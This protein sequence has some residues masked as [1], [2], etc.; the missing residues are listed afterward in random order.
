MQRARESAAE[1][2]S[3]S[4][5]LVTRFTQKRQSARLTKNEERYGGFAEF[6]RGLMHAA[7]CTPLT[8]IKSHVI[9]LLPVR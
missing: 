2:H 4:L 3:P 7:H 1:T 9:P 5:S 8:P 6:S